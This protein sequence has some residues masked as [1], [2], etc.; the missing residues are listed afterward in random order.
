M[1][2][3]VDRRPGRPSLCRRLGDLA[4]LEQPLAFKIFEVDHVIPRARGGADHL[5]NLQL[6]CPNCNRI[7]GDR[8]QE[9][10]MARLAEMA[11]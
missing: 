1:S 7:K 11:G 8:P 2:S 6:L 10:L 5:E 9:W 3:I 4:V